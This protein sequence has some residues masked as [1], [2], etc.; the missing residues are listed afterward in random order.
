MPPI[1]FLRK[2]RDLCFLNRRIYSRVASLRMSMTC[3]HPHLHILTCDASNCWRFEVIYRAPA[4]FLLCSDNAP[5]AYNL[6]RCS[7]DA[8]VDRIFQ[9]FHPHDLANLPSVHDGSCVDWMSKDS[10]HHNCHRLRSHSLGR[11][12]SY[13]PYLSYSSYSSYL[14]LLQDC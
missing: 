13:L 10:L 6:G 1:S 7:G 14:R 5:L 8:A 12:W 9:Q 2:I 3:A 4:Y 11:F